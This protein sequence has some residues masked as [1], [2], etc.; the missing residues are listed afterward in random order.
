MRIILLMLGGF[1]LDGIFGDPAWLVHPVVIM[2]KAITALEKF[3]RKRLP[4]TSEGERLG[5]RILAMALPVGT[6]LIT[7][8][9]LLAV[10]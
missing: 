1:I 7:G 9:G 5:G 8:G 10:L 2:G 4:N 3:L 6:L